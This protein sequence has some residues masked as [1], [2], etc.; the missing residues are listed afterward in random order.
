[1]TNVEQIFM[2]DNEHLGIFLSSLCC[3]IRDTIIFVLKRECFKRWT[4]GKHT[5]GRSMQETAVCIIFFCSFSFISLYPASQLNLKFLRSI[6]TLCLLPR[7]SHQV[8]PLLGC[9][10]TH[11][12][13]GSPV[14][15][16]WLCYIIAFFGILWGKVTSLCHSWGTEAWGSEHFPRV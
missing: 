4:R 8:I 7:T 9:G 14:C 11:R 15:S 2:S 13:W 6:T 16:V 10:R 3:V 1:M 12:L 5:E